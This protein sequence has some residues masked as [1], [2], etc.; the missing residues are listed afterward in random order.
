MINEGFGVVGKYKT[1]K[2]NGK[3]IGEHR[4]IIQEII[5][6]ELMRDEVVHHKNGNPS[7]NRIENLEVMTLSEHSRIHMIKIYADGMRPGLI[8]YGEDHPRAKLSNADVADIRRR[9][10]GRHNVSQIARDY[11][12]DRWT[13]RMIRD[14]KLRKN[15]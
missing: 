2:I 5:G 6:R 14:G 9:C 10:V 11:S 7:D 3:A 1:L 15:G 4:H 8:R 13:I 12:V